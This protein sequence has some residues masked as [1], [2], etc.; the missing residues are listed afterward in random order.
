MRFIYQNT[1][2]T[3]IELLPRL[4]IMY[5]RFCYGIA[6]EWLFFSFALV[7]DHD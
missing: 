4:T 6:F 3:Q 2:K 7:K 5:Y 1:F